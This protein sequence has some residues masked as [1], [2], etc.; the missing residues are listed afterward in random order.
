MRQVTSSSLF[1][2]F[3]RWCHSRDRTEL[4]K[5]PNYRT[6]WPHAS[7]GAIR[8]RAWSRHPS[9]SGQTGQAGDPGSHHRYPASPHSRVSPH[10]ISPLAN[11]NLRRK[12]QA[13]D[14]R[15]F[16]RLSPPHGTPM[17]NSPF[18]ANLLHLRNF[19]GIF[20]SK[21]RPGC[22]HFV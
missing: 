13:A 10:S 20:V 2:F 9:R 7:C 22:H 15:E 17:S 6:R 21:H 4:S 11:A 14:G 18:P 5:T 16:I 12:N 19:D 3:R 8:N 1:K